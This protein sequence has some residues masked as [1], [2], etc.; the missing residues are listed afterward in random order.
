LDRENS[1]T[2]SEAV[3]RDLEVALVR[4]ARVLFDFT[5]S[6]DDFNQ[7]ARLDPLFDE[8]CRRVDEYHNQT[9]RLHPDL[10][11]ELGEWASF[12]SELLSPDHDKHVAEGKSNIDRAFV[13]NYG[14]T[15]ENIIR[16][17]EHELGIT[18]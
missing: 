17:L 18:E 4:I 6:Q 16:G 9:G 15:P 7:F 12:K 11:L 8:L 5:K 3:N 10:G 2:P 1:T 13:D 14:K